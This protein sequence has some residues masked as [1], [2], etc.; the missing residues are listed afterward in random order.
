MLPAY[1]IKRSKLKSTAPALLLSIFKTMTFIVA[2][3]VTKCGDFQVDG[4]F[5]LELMQVLQDMTHACH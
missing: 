5:Q 2:Y 1:C 3:S 4:D